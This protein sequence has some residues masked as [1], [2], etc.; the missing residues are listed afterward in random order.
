MTG[1][2]FQMTP[3]LNE[4]VVH[5]RVNEARDR[6]E[7]RRTARVARAGTMRR[8]GLQSIRDA[9]GH[10]LIAIGERLMDQPPMSDPAA[11]RRAA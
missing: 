11:D 10:G 2:E 5:D 7:S 1:R 3:M 6:A 8:R 4:T 9:V